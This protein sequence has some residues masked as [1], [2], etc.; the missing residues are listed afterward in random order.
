MKTNS[1]IEDVVRVVAQLRGPGGCPWDRQQNHKSICKH[2]IEEVYELLDAV[3]ANDD[4]AMQEEL[5]D[6]LLHVVFHCQI[7]KERRAFD[8]DTVC[9]KLASKLIRRHPHVFG[10]VRV[11]SV[12]EV[13]VNWE[14]IKRAEKQGTPHCRKSALDG[15]PKHLP[16]LMRAEKLIKKARQAELMPLKKTQPQAASKKT[17]AKKLFELVELAQ[18]RGWSAEELLRTELRRR[19]KALRRI[20]ARRRQDNEQ[21]GAYKHST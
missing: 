5:G 13:W 1:P 9:R 12:D 21:K 19:E 4:E 3:E 8:F 11:N 20:E 15:I 17:I 7:A 10:N 2:A 16:A 14:K 18:R 6:L